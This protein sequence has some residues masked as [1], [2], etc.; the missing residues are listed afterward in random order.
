[1][2]HRKPTKFSIFLVVLLILCCILLYWYANDNETH[3]TAILVLGGGLT[4]S[5]Q[6]PLHTQLRLEKAVSLLKKYPGSVIITLSG[7]TPHKPNPL[8]LN[9]F[10]IWESSAAAKKLVEMGVSAENVF[11]ENFSLDT[12]G[13][14]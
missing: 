11:E 4:S 10:P 1:M 9:G 2:V 5:G 13:N 6:V 14:V 3:S 7:G 12:V 8:D